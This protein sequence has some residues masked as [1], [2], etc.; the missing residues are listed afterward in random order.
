MAMFKRF[1]VLGAVL[2]AAASGCKRDDRYAG[3]RGNPGT[4]AN[5]APIEPAGSAGS[6]PEPTGPSPGTPPPSTEPSTGTPPP[7]PPPSYSSD[8]GVDGGAASTTP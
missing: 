8:G 2:I 4:N 3:Q 6:A 5:P 7:S 1:L